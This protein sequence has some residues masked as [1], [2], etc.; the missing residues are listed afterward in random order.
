V[1][2]KIENRHDNLGALNI[3]D[4]K[5]NNL[6]EKV[7][8]LQQY[9]PKLL[10]IKEDV[11]GKTD[12]KD[13]ISKRNDNSK[14]ILDN[15]KNIARA[16]CEYTKNNKKKFDTDEFNKK[17]TLKS[18]QKVRIEDLL[19]IFIDDLELAKKFLTFVIEDLGQQYQTELDQLTQI[20]LYHRLLEYMLYSR[21]INEK[22]KIMPSRYESDPNAFKN[23]IAAFISRYDQKIDKNYMLFLFQ[24]YKVSDGVKDCC[25]RLGLKQELLNYYIQQDDRDQVMAVC[26]EYAQ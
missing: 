7:Q 13:A 2:I 25:E 21:Q 6:K 5:I 18:H 22:K 20:N 3:I 9:V 24:I 19:Q 8:C 17:F 4:Q 14:R 23:Q 16:L 10:K 11:S 12:L 15:V 1:Q 26:Q